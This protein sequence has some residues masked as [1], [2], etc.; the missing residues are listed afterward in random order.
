M[1]KKNLLSESTIRKFMK[2][3]NIDNLADNFLQEGAYMEEG[4]YDAVDEMAPPMEE[5]EDADL[6]AMDDV[7]DDMD[8]MDDMDAVDDMADMEAEA[9]EELPPEAVAALERAVEDAVDSLLASLAPYGVQGDV[10]VEDDVA[11]E[12]PGDEG[13]EDDAV[14]VDDEEG[15][16]VIDEEEI[17]NETLNRVTRRLRAM[18]ESR[19]AEAKRD[20][21]ADRIASAVAKRLRK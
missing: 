9:G 11:A 19:K 18:N 8:D 3:A 20:E 13:P 12:L 1:S 2:F 21:L 4:E 10:E 16:D 17:V 7:A 5:E 15:L 6:D 14:A